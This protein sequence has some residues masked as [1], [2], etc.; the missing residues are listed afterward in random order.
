M[1]AA[2]AAMTWDDAGRDGMV[3]TT[4]GTIWCGAKKKLPPWPPALPHPPPHPAPTHPWVV[5]FPHPRCALV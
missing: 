1:D 2:V 5:W 3:M 4:A